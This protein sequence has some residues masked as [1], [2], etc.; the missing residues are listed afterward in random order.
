MNSTLAKT[1]ERRNAPTRA[2]IERR[3][4]RFDVRYRDRIRALAGQH[5]R[6]AD[7]ALS[8]PALLFALAT[9]CA[10][11][12]P[13][14]VTAEVI[15]GAPLNTLGAL[16]RL[17]LWLRALQPEAFVRPIG[18]LPDGEFVRRQIAN[19][20]PR[21]PK[22]Q[23]DWLSVL[24]DA[25]AW[26]NASIAVWIAREAGRDDEKSGDRKSTRLNSSH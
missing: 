15:A 1:G 9:P 23:A 4:A 8:F 20:A 24:Y 26:G 22:R 6:L 3:L 5:S 16:A 12:D 10:R 7:L 2:L 18:D 13:E 11:F 25:F 21:S 19:Y 14:P 17:P